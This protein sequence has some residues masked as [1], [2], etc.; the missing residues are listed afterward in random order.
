MAGPLLQRKLQQLPIR[1]EGRLLE[2]ADSMRPSLCLMSRTTSHNDNDQDIF[3]TFH[4][5][6]CNRPSLKMLF[7]ETLAA[8]D[9]NNHCHLRLDLGSVATVC[10]FHRHRNGSGFQAAGPCTVSY[11]LV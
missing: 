2:A 7:L 10:P 4:P 9:D 8:L 5:V 11:F 3:E 6:R 1:L